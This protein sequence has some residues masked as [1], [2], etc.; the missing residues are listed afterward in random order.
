M[1]LPFT[2]GDADLHR[3]FELTSPRKLVLDIHFQRLEFLQRDLIGQLGI[4]VSDARHDRSSQGFTCIV[5]AHRSL[6]RVE[7]LIITGELVADVVN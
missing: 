7:K 4:C 5:R 1:P 3:A 2:K 6:H